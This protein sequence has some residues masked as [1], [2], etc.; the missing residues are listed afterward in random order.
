MASVQLC[1]QWKT[2]LEDKRTPERVRPEIQVAMSMV[3]KAKHAGVSGNLELAILGLREATTC[4][5]A[6]LSDTQKL[7]ADAGMPSSI[8][9]RCVPT[10]DTALRRPMDGLSG[11]NE[12]CLD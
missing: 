3:A 2:V 7:T 5:L 6:A 12:Q 9:I 1:L 11:A 10:C 8:K 4:V